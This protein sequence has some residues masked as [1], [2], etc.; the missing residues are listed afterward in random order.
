M[1]PMLNLKRIR[2][3][4]PQENEPETAYAAPQEQ[5]RRRGRRALIFVCVLAVVAAGIFYVR[6][7]STWRAVFLTNN[8]VYFG[9]FVDV[10]FWPTVT[11]KNIY[12][13]QVSQPLQP[14]EGQ[15]QPELKIVKLGQEIHGPDDM[16]VIPKSQILFWENLRETSLVVKTIREAQKSGQ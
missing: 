16:M 7:G 9:R 10:P 15:G 5:P 13:L 6:A 4:S 11:L 2:P 3:E 8:Q 14:G 12:Y 1:N